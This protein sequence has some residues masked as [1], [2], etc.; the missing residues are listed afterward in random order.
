MQTYTPEEKKSR[1]RTRRLFPPPALRRALPRYR[2]I[3]M[4]SSATS[5]LYNT[6]LV[7]EVADRTTEGQDYVQKWLV[8]RN[9]YYKPGASTQA[10]KFERLCRAIEQVLTHADDAAS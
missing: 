3:L 2:Q 10:E 7:A 6:G 1:R 8:T 5:Q 4:R 9:F